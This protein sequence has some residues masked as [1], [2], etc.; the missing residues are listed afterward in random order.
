[1][2]I[3]I[4]IQNQHGGWNPY[5]T[6]NH[7]PSAYREALSLSKTKGK[8]VRLMDSSGILLDVLNP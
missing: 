5:A 3:F 2:K 6:S 4:Q 1:M 8:R 7:Q